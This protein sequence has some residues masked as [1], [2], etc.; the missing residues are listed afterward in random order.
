MAMINNPNKGWVGIEK[1]ILDFILKDLPKSGGGQK[2]PDLG[3]KLP[4]LGRKL[5]ELAMRIPPN[6]LAQLAVVAGGG[7][8]GY[9][10]GKELDEQFDL[11]GKLAEWLMPDPDMSGAKDMPSPQP[12]AM[13]PQPQE[14]Y[15]EGETEAMIEDLQ[16]IFQ[17]MMQTPP[18]SKFRWK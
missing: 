17:P 6:L 16:K 10:I 11:S 1:S 7:Y 9:N 14:D 5:P 4:D 15:Y 8:A 2:I 13:Y 12:K 3:R 18:M